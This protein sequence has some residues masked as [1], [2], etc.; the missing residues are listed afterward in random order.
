MM[1]RTVCVSPAAG[2]SPLA[3]FA[4]HTRCFAGKAAPCPSAASRPASVN[5]ITARAA[6]PLPAGSAARITSPGGAS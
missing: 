6:T 1:W 2:T 4:S 5:P 3:S